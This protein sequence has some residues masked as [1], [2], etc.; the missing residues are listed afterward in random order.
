MDIAR[1]TKARQ[2]RGETSLEALLR[3]PSRASPQELAGRRRTLLPLALDSD[4]NRSLYRSLSFHKAK[5]GIGMEECQLQWWWTHAEA[6]LSA[7]T[8]KHFPQ[9]LLLF[10]VGDYSQL[11]VT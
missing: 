5:P 6:Q 10:L 3:E 9:P 4:D 8:C 7:L 1:T 2:R 11:Q